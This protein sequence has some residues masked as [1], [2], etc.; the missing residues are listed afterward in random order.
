M[1]AVYYEPVA[2]KSD[3]KAGKQSLRFRS[4]RTDPM[5]WPYQQRAMQA[6]RGDRVGG[7]ELP[8]WENRLND[9]EAA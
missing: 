5:S 1:A 8:M 6:V 4:A 3:V 2:K 9:F 7:G